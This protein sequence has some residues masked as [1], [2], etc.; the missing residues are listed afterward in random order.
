MNSLHLKSAT[1]A[2]AI[3]ALN[4]VVGCASVPSVESL[5]TSVGSNRCAAGGLSGVFQSATNYMSWANAGLEQI[6][7][8]SP[9]C[10]APTHE[11]R[12]LMTTVMLD[13]AALSSAIGVDRAQEALGLKRTLQAEIAELQRKLT[14][15]GTGGSDE[16]QTVILE[17]RAQSAELETKLAELIAN[18]ALNEDAIQKLAQ[19]RAELDNVTYYA[20]SATTG[21]VLYSRYLKEPGVSIETKTSGLVNAGLVREEFV[22]S[23]AE[24]PGDVA[25]AFRS[26][27]ALSATIKKIDQD[28]ELPDADR[29]DAEEQAQADLDRIGEQLAGFSLTQTSV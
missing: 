11:Q 16:S 19:A 25:S 29:T 10:K 2:F 28:V 22:N 23:L 17:V 27:V 18:R 5:T 3:L 7:P 6:S 13:R 14:G 4:V 9:I 21:A 12:L 26:T 1:G 8:L 20:A 15:L 24:A